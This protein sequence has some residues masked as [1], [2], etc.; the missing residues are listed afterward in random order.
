[1]GP[2]KRSRSEAIDVSEEQSNEAPG[3]LQRLRSSWQFANVMQYIHIFGKLMK[4]DE[5][6]GIEVC[7][8]RPLIDAQPDKNEMRVALSLARLPGFNITFSRKF[9]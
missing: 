1:M 7:G 4:I 5:D 3:L 8:N 6:F 9:T 2:R